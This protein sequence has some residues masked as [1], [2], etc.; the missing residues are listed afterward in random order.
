MATI[1]LLLISVAQT[2]V[3]SDTEEWT[4]PIGIPKPPFGID[5]SY[6]MYD[7]QSARN[8]SLCYQPSKEG[9]YYT[10]YVDSTEPNATDKSNSY[11]TVDK[12]RKTVPYPLAAGSVVEIH[13]AGEFESKYY[14]VCN[15]TE[16]MPVFIRG[17]GDPYFETEGIIKGQYAIIEGIKLHTG[18]IQIRTHLGSSAHHICVRNCEVYAD[19]VLY[20]NA[21]IDVGNTDGQVKDFNN[22]VIYN[23]YIH[24]DGDCSPNS[25]EASNDSGGVHVGS[26]TSYVWILDN[27]ICRMG[28]DSILLCHNA[29]FTSHHI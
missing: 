27:E 29:N 2:I 21:G 6:R 3:P 1:L 18:H 22:V 24:D 15:G 11:G 28:G 13:N 16:A 17:V 9:G 19:G 26:Y 25:P 20:S 10:H 23:N 12:P 14:V 5:E 4:P 7:G 8:P